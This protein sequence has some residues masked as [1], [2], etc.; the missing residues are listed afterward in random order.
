MMT[1]TEIQSELWGKAP[2]DWALIQEPTDRPLSEPTHRPLWE[3]LLDEVLVGITII[4]VTL[5]IATILQLSY[6]L[7]LAQ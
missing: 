1:M 7:F 6:T 2:Q 4:G 3:A 5:L